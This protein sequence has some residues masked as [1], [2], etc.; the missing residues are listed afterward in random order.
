MLHIKVQAS[1]Q[2]GSEE[3]DFLIFFMYFYGLNLG[4][5]A[6]GHLGPWDLHFKKKTW[7]RTTRQ[8]YISS[9]ISNSLTVWFCRR[10][11]LNIFMLFYVKI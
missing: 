8:F 4:P 7:L 10:R 9:Q 3:E 5:L 6:L 2:S 11:V 1:E